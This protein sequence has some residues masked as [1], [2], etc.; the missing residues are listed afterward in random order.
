MNRKTFFLFSFIFC[1]SILQ[2]QNPTLVLPVGHSGRVENII[3]TPDGKQMISSAQ[4]EIKVWDVRNK[5][6]LYTLSNNSLS[7]SNS[8]KH[9]SMD[10]KKLLTIQ[11]SAIIKI[12][13]VSDGTIYQTI[14]GNNGFINSVSYCHHNEDIVVS[15]QDGSIKIYDGKTGKLKV[16]FHNKDQPGLIAFYSHDD[17]LIIVEYDQNIRIY[18]I[19]GESELATINLETLGT[20]SKEINITEDNHYLI[21]HNYDSTL[22]VW[23]I[24]SKKKTTLFE[25]KYIEFA[26]SKDSKT[27]ALIDKKELLVYKTGDDKPSYRTPMK[28]SQL[29]LSNNGRFLLISAEGDSSRQTITLLDLSTQNVKYK[30]I[31]DYSFFKP[32]IDDNGNFIM[33]TSFQHNSINLFDFNTGRL[34]GNFTQQSVPVLNIIPGDSANI[35]MTT[36]MDSLVRIWDIKTGEIINYVHLEN[37]SVFQPISTKYIIDIKRSQYNEDGTSNKDTIIVLEAR[38]GKIIRHIIPPSLYLISIYLSPD[39]KYLVLSYLGSVNILDFKTGKLI[40]SIPNFINE[41]DKIF[42]IPQSGQMITTST[43]IGNEA[44]IWDIKTGNKI[45]KVENNSANRVNDSWI[46]DYSISENG[47]YLSTASNDNFLKIYDLKKQKI[48]KS[49]SQ[50]QPFF[51]GQFSPDGKYLCAGM[52]DG[53]VIIVNMTTLEIIKKVKVHEN[54]VYNISYTKDSR[55][56]ITA[57]NDGTVKIWDMLSLN[58]I[59]TIKTGGAIFKRLDHGKLY[60]TDNAEISVF[61]FN[62]GQK[63]FSFAALLK[64]GAMF[65]LPGNYY[66]TSV[67]VSK[68]LS[69]KKGSALYGFDQLDVKYNRPDLVLQA[70]GNTDTVLIKSYKKAYEKRI[71]R[72]GF[73]TSQFTGTF[74]VPD[75]EIVNRDKITFERKDSNL[76]LYISAKDTSFILDRF[77]VWINEVP[78]F[79]TKGISLEWRNKKDFDTTLTVTLSDGLNIIETSVTNISG[80]ESYRMPLQINYTPQQKAKEI[81]HFIGIGI[82]KFNNNTYNLQWSVKDVRDLTDSLKSKYGSDIVIDTLFNESVT[83]PNI[84]ALKK[85]LLQTKENDKVIIAY[86]GH[87]LLSDSLDY[88]LST[89]NVNFE[90]PEEGGL[91]YDALENLLDSIPARNKL[92]LIDAC[93]SGEVDKDE[94]LN[95]TRQKKSL[96]DSATKGIIKFSRD[97]SKLG[98]KNSFE[99]MQQLFVNVGRSTGATIISAAAGTQFALERGDLKNGVFTYSILEYMKGHPSATVTEL[100]NY[101]N[102]RVPELTKGLQQ[103]TSRTENKVVDWTIW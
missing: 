85:K 100:K 21:L 6:L 94:M 99:L 86:S 20:S 62:T 67:E 23:D 64:T 11:G 31:T 9:L 98:M 1:T 89:Y 66:K 65:V 102:K 84:T 70:L 10:G 60:F 3:I 33:S 53:S 24:L 92:M 74:N 71:K 26:I 13:N 35:I 83:T 4:E 42:F 2:A 19:D 52:R 49:F 96:E 61:D 41:I 18:K 12:W 22:Y 78:L 25:T 46:Q 37:N 15:Y 91:P 39:N 38:S 16:N 63:I 80:L 56:M 103:P 43:L 73:N 79:G 97:P 8:S 93:H 51:S 27:I 45:F 54:Y 81:L 30:F 59:R 101:V 5:K 82:D 90:K 7:F 77:N 76:T 29:T 34:Y 72:L 69:W 88:Y 48:I 47:R 40:S 36:S 87:G 58:P 95:Y 28:S 44:D 50:L 55:F 68:Y 17:K 75:A 57:A 14:D 32:Q